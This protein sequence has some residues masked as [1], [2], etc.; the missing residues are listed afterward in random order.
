VNRSR[1]TRELP[2]AVVVPYA[3]I[4][5]GLFLLALWAVV[6][7]AAAIESTDWL[8]AL[9]RGAELTR[10]S[11]WHALG[12]VISVG[13]INGVIERVCGAAV[14]Q[15]SPCGARGRSRGADDHAVV[16]ALTSAMLYY[17]LCARAAGQA[18]G[19]NG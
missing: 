11:R 1:W 5:P 12:V 3:V 16:A 15:A 14:G 6:A 19:P 9:R 17:D 4:V 8:G 7:Q 18:G 2:L 13:L 10:G